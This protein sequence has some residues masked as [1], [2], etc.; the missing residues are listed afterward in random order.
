MSRRSFRAEHEGFSLG[1]ASRDSDQCSGRQQ[2][3]HQTHKDLPIL[4][5][6]PRT[7]FDNHRGLAANKAFFA[8]RCN[9]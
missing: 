5:F 1:H 3:F 9:G 6:A 8:A 7:F 2:G 4:I